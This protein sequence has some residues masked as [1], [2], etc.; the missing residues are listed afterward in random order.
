[1]DGKLLNVLNQA[2][3]ATERAAKVGNNVDFAFVEHKIPRI[4]AA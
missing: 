1:M 2:H 3:R 4:F